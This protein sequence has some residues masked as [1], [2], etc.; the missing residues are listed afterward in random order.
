LKEGGGSIYWEKKAN[1]AAGQTP[2]K[3]GGWF[4]FVGKVAPKERAKGEKKTAWFFMGQQRSGTEG[5]GV[6]RKPNPDP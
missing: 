3:T 6:C 2:K 1:R 5:V 4:S